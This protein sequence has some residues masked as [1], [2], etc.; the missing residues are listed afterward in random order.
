ML[1]DKVDAV[2]GADT[3]LVLRVWLDD[4]AIQPTNYI[5]LSKATNSCI[6]VVQSKSAPINILQGI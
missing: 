5:Q 6:A 4:E 1:A 2:F 3:L